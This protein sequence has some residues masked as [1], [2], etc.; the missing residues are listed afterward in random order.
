[1]KYP[2]SS[3]SFD[4]NDKDKNIDDK[5]REYDKFSTDIAQ[6]LGLA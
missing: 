6:T 3:V 4:F 5:A 1:M 2:T